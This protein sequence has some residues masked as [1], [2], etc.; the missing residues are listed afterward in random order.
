MKK[1]YQALLILPIAL[2]FGCTGVRAWADSST[3]IIQS[4]T[5]T[6]T[7]QQSTSATPMT[8]SNDADTQALSLHDQAVVMAHQAT[9]AAQHGER[10]LAIQLAA[11]AQDLFC[12][13]NTHAQQFYAH[14]RGQQ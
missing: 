6:T 8:A 14:R 5:T 10:K 7:T 2:A 3:P 9:W 11:Q 4:T 13:A 12:Q 1:R